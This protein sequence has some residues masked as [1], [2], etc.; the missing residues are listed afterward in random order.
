MLVH[1][2]DAVRVAVD[3]DGDQRYEAWLDLAWRYLFEPFGNAAPV[4]NPG[5]YLETPLG[6]TVALDGSGSFDWEGTPLSYQW[7]LIQRPAG[8]KASLA[9]AKTATP[10]LTPDVAGAYV[11]ELT[12]HDGERA[13]APARVLVT[14]K[15]PN[16][17][18]VC[19][20]DDLGGL[21]ESGYITF[22]MRGSID[23]A[24]V[25]PLCSGRVLVANSFGPDS[26]FLGTGVTVWNVA[27]GRAEREYDLT[28]AVESIVLDADNGWV[29]ATGAWG[30]VARI[31][32]VSHEVTHFLPG[33]AYQRIAVAP[34][35]RLFGVR[36]AA[37]DTL[38]LDIIDGGALAVLKS[39]GLREFGTHAVPSDLVVTADG[40]VIVGAYGG[41]DR[42]QRYRWNPATND[43]ALVELV[44]A[45]LWPRDTLAAAPDGTRYAL[46]ARYLEESE[47]SAQSLGI[48]DL[49]TAFA[50]QGFW[51]T[52][53]AP[54]S[55][56][57]DVLG[58]YLVAATG[59]GAKVFDAAAHTAVAE[60][61]HERGIADG[62]PDHCDRLDSR[63]T[64]AAMSRG[65][66][67]LYGLAGSCG[68]MHS[69]TRLYWKVWRR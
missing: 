24:R 53:W 1:S 12:V 16:G 57:F 60:I 48:R 62:S 3:Q 68:P 31:D 43:I 32:L 37:D 33:H 42:V 9:G 69:Q 10:T 23:N 59:V 7:T 52:G 28:D 66:E 40:E 5:R 25:I 21:P 14:G 17:R 39:V 30:G 45:N 26:G 67:I 41:V 46:Q 2:G 51:F 50:D 34:G 38:V 65:G 6:A 36:N 20:E 13:S 15:A 58:N 47:W 63:M 35:G 27:T 49:D 18:A 44:V 56:A 64:A 11:A 29:F 19:A 54:R 55:A 61:A 4:A 22:E 8:S